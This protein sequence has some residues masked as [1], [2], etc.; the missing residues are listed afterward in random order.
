M[1]LW[2]GLPLLLNTQEVLSSNLGPETGYRE[3]FHGFPQSL[4]EKAGMVL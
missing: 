4:Q 3:Y 2:E 1:F